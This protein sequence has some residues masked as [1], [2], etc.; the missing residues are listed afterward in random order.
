MV[1]LT[2]IAL[3]NVLLRGDSLAALAWYLAHA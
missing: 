2:W 3:V 1:R